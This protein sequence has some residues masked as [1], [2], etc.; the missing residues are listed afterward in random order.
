MTAG[1][2]GRRGILTA[3]LVAGA[4]HGALALAGVFAGLE[5]TYAHADQVSYHA[6]T[7]AKMAEEMP[8]PVLSDY[9]SATAPGFH[10]VMSSLAALGADATVLRVLNALIGAA[11]VAF[12]TALVGFATALVSFPTALGSF[13]TALVSFPTALVGARAGGAATLAFGAAFA[14]SPYTLNPSIWLAT[15]NL[16]T[17]F[18]LAAFAAAMPLAAGRAPRAAVAGAAASILA[19][20]AVGVRQIMAYAAALPGAAIVAR[21]CAER[22]MPSAGALLA[23]GVAVVPALA[24]VAVLAWL[25]GG[26]VPPSF[27]QYH[28][29]GGNSATPVYALALV[30]IW[31]FAAFLGIPGFLRELFTPRIA[32]VALLAGAACC[33]VPSSYVVHVRF[34]GV[35]WTIASKFPAVMERSLL[36]V[37]LAALGAAA[38]AAYLRLWSRAQ[39]TAAR[40]VG[41]YALFALLGSVAAQTANSQCFERYLQP[42]VLVFTAIAAMT[43]AGRS[44]R[45]WP[46]VAAAALSAALSA[47]NILRGGA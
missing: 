4:L 33:L 47:M 5:G 27:Q 7:I 36:L 26:L 11:L 21:A 42:P 40:G 43:L 23:A 30:G 37:P 45:A 12:A 46:L 41:A 39:D 19:V 9:Q 24:L 38:I 2:V 8:R 18:V 20:A 29:G 3:A 28:G 13:P 6:P 32:L 35:L 25:W 1:A 16:A 17:L 34:G 10:L 22:R 15:D 31:G 14:L 44:Y